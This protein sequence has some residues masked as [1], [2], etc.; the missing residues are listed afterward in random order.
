MKFGIDIPGTMKEAV[1]L[2]EAN[3]NNIW[4][5]SMKLKMKNSRVAFKLCEKGEK[6]TVGHTKIT[7]HLIFDLKLDMTRKARYVPGEY[8]TDVLK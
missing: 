4:Q 5:D 3:G 1:Y 6:V 7:C 2:D 8:L